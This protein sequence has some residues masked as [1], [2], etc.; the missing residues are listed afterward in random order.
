MKK[1]E[2]NIHAGHRKRLMELAYKSDFDNLS[3]IQQVELVLCYVF[4]RGD[5]NPLAHRLLDR[6]KNLKTILEAPIE[7]L[8]QVDGMG[9]MSAL[10]LHN[11]LGVFE[12]Y[13][14]QK[15]KKEAKMSTLGEIY[16]YIEDLLRFK[17]IEE[18]HI[19][20][21]NEQGEVVCDRCL[22]RGKHSLVSVNL[23]DI[24]LFV[25]TYDVPA[26]ILVHNHPNGECKSSSQDVFTH[27]KLDG[28]FK[29]SGCKLVDNLIVGIDGIYSLKDARMKR[30]F[31]DSELYN[32]A[33]DQLN[34]IGKFDDDDD[35]DED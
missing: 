9:Y 11:L 4:P 26:V 25:T 10:K 24:S 1:I 12:G 2:N 8:Q 20:G 33:I 3:V 32:Q 7:D 17:K 34:Q 5:V 29:F 35:F 23:K 22:A 27:D 14:L 16:D 15:A 6:Y 31:L 19:L 28:V 30:T 21:I 18:V 13:V